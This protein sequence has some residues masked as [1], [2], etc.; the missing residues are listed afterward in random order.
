[1]NK[2]HQRSLTPIEMLLGVAV[3]GIA[4]TLA[5]P[6]YRNHTIDTQIRDGLRLG[7]HWKHAVVE[8]YAT[9]GVW[10]SKSAIEDMAPAADEVASVSV[11]AGVIRIHYVGAAVHPQLYGA[12]LTLVPYTGVKGDVTWQCGRAPA[13]RGTPAMREADAGT[14]LTPRQLPTGCGS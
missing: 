11:E 2:K 14:T 3:L 13:P 5:A 10:P 12:V 6:A 8:Y 4:S 1:M 9:N 7:G